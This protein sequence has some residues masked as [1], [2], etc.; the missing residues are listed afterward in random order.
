MDGTA[1][2]RRVVEVEELKLAESASSIG[3]ARQELCRSQ[4]V[5]VA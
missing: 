4:K 2:A 3:I 1:R 5:N